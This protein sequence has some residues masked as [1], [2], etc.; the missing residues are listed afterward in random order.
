MKLQ[1]TKARPV[2]TIVVGKIRA[3]IWQTVN[4]RGTF[5]RITLER[6]YRDKDGKWQSARSFNAGTDVRALI[7]AAARANDKIVSATMGAECWE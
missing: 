5:H 1:Q 2:A 4:E 3:N 7:E 6:R